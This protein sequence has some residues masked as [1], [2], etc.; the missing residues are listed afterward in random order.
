M[1]TEPGVMEGVV[2]RR[3]GVRPREKKLM[4]F[5]EDHT[6]ILVEKVSKRV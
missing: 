5:R 2:G 3:F 1:T 6:P 4:V